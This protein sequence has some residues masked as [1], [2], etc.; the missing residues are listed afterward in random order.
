MKLME[1]ILSEENLKMAIKKVKQNK[2][3][4]GIDKMTVQ[5]VEQW[6]E[7][8]REEI[9][10]QIMSKK[11]RPMPVKRVYIPKPNGKKRPLGIPTVVDRVIQQAISQILTTV[12]EPIFSEHS[13]G[14]RPKRSAHMAME[15]V[16]YYLNEGMNG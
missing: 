8:Y 4:P 11:Y 6:F 12:Y 15:E 1:K 3:A 16:L 9:I 7:Q 13:Y 2:G 5:E 14:F 10:T